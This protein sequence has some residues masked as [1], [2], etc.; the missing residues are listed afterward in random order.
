MGVVSGRVGPPQVNGC[1]LDRLIVH[2]NDQ[3]LNEY[4]GAQRLIRRAVHHRPQINDE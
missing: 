3:A 2:V 1:I 4:P